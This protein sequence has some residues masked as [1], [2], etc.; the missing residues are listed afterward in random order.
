MRLRWRGLEL[1]ARV[2]RDET[3]SNQKFGRFTAEPFER[4]FGTTVGNSLRRILL[5]SLE[6]AAIT[7]VRIAGADHEFCSLP[8]VYE[9]VTDIILNIKSLVVSIDG[10]GPKT[11]R[12]ERTKAGAI[13][14]ADI[15]CEA[16]VEIFNK[17]QPIA[18]LTDNVKF[19]LELRADVGRGYVPA[20]ELV[21]DDTELGI[22]AVDALY[23]PVTRVRYRTEETRV[24]QKTNYDRLILE[25]WTKGTVAPEDAMVEAGKILRKHL[26]PFVQ[27]HELGQDQAAA[28]SSQAPSAQPPIDAELLR[29]LQMP[30]RDLDLSVR[31]SNCLDSV[32]VLTVGDLVRRDESE[33]MQLRSFGRTSLDEVQQKLG[34][35]GLELGMRDLPPLKSGLGDG[36]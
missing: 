22:I 15:E 1:P 21:D 14:A 2:L 3:I 7:H 23:S 30:L 11:M 5:S 9:D 25:I 18:T 19:S 26:N 17:E 33:L 27:Y 8:G 34:E 20:S 36:L 24:G 28:D 6:G 10:E 4:G 35:M 12:V 31:A 16:G 13:T 32:N 29:K